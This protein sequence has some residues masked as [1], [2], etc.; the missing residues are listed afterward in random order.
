MFDLEKDPKEM[1]SVH[2]SPEYSDVLAKMK[3]ELAKI[4]KQYDVTEAPKLRKGKTLFPPWKEF[5]TFKIE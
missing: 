2:A 1:T 5:G 3:V 4:R